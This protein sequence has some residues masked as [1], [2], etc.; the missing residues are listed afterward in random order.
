MNRYKE[1]DFETIYHATFKALSKHVYFKVAQTSDAEDIVQNVYTNFYHYVHKKGKPIDN[2]QAYLIQMANNELKTYYQNKTNEPITL[3]DDLDILENI[4]DESDL[5]MD[6]IEKFEIEAIAEAIK[7]L[8]L[9]DQKIMGA[10]F[11]FELTFREISVQL[12]IPENTVKTRYYR[13]LGQ[14]KSVLVGTSE[15]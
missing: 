14:L 4:P 2:V 11:R 3:D 13:A 10:R 12:D 15:T 6:I 9:I 5:A 7:K 8:P 1:Q